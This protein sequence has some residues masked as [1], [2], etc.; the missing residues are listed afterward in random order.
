M[1]RK[2]VI[3]AMYVHLWQDGN[4][5]ENIA[6][7]VAI[8]VA[9]EA[10]GVPGRTLRHWVVRGKV[11]AINGHAGKLVRLDDVMR[12]AA[13]VGKIDGN[14]TTEDGKDG[15][16]AGYIATDLATGVATSP[17]TQLTAVM[18]EWVLPLVERIGAL[19]RENGMLTAERDALQRRIETL[20]EAGGPTSPHAA[21][22][23]AER[24]PEVFPKQRWPWWMRLLAG[25]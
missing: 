4:M 7:Y 23:G 17:R 14:A 3:L 12:L 16:I 21:P 20:E 11:A 19:E 13:M 22:G 18:D 24:E 15:K 1:A 25:K 5:A 10:S 8:K 9:S 6:N 2:Q